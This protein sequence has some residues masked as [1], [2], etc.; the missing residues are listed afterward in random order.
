MIEDYEQAN[1]VRD[2]HLFRVSEAA[3]VLCRGGARYTATI[4]D[5][6]RAPLHRSFLP[7][8]GARHRGERT[9]GGVG[10]G[11]RSIG[12]NA[13]HPGTRPGQPVIKGTLNTYRDFVPHGASRG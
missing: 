1:T 8:A 13:R 6:H 4:R 10:R 2:L 7:D 3:P 11:T 12:G 9:G 5:Y